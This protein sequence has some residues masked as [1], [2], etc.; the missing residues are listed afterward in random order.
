MLSKTIGRVVR[1]ATMA[2]VAT[3]VAA[4]ATLTET[5][6]ARADD[7]NA[8]LSSA[9]DGPSTSSPARRRR[10]GF[11]RA[12]RLGGPDAGSDRPS[13]PRARSRGVRVAS[14]GH[15]ALSG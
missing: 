15:D 3:F 12:M 6:P 10:G 13:R 4:A 14:L 8:W 9:L 5:A 7:A 11:T 2:V 1:A